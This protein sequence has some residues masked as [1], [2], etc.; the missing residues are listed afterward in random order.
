MALGTQPVGKLLDYEQYIEHQIQRTRARIKMTDVLTACLILATAAL[1]ILFLEVLLDHLVGLP[2]WLRRIVLWS[3]L[4]GGATFAVLRVARPLIS[5]V[6]GLY[7]AKTIEGVDPAFKNSL[8]NYLTLRRRPDAVSR[9]FM[10]AVEAKAVKDLTG[11]EIDAVVDQR[12]LLQMFYALAGVVVIFCLYAA[13][14]PK[15]ILDSAKRA[16]VLDVVRP[17]NTRLVNIKPGDNEELSRVVSGSNV[18]FSVDLQGTRPGRVILHYSVDGGKYYTTTEFAPGANYYDPWQVTLRDV[19]QSLD[20]YLTGG[21]AESLKYHLKVLPAPMVT[22]VS[23]DYEFPAYTGVPPRQDVEGGEIEAIEG[24]RVTVKARTNEPAVSAYFDFSKGPNKNPPMNVSETD[25]HL[26]VGTFE[27]RDSGSYTIKFKTT[28]GQIN[29]DPVVYDIKAI[30]DKAP[31]EVAFLRPDKPEITVPC[32]VQV[33]LVMTASDDFGVKEVLL[34]VREGNETLYSVNLLEKQKPTRRW[35]GGFTIDLA[36]K[37]LKPGAQVEYMMTVRDTKEPIPNRAESTRQVIKVG[38]PV[39]DDERKKINDKAR[40]ETRDAEKPTPPEPGE[41][42]EN[43]N[44]PPPTPIEDKPGADRENPNQTEKPSPAPNAKGNERD[45]GGAENPEQAPGNEPPPMSPEQLARIEKTLNRSRAQQNNNGKTQAPQN[46][47]PSGAPGAGNPQATQPPPDN[48]NPSGPNS[49]SISQGA[50][51]TTPNPGATTD[52]GTTSPPPQGNPGTNPANDSI[53]RAPEPNTAPTSNPPASNN[54]QAQKPGDNNSQPQPSRPSQPGTPGANASNPAATG[55]PNTAKPQSGGQSGSPDA[56]SATKPADTNT[57]PGGTPPP[58]GTSN[59]NTNPQARPAGDSNSPTTSNPGTKPSDSN[60]NSNPT[61]T[62]P[63]PPTTG[64][65][66]PKP[67]DDKSQGQSNK[68]PGSQENQQ[69]GAGKPGGSNSADASNP[70]PG[71][72]NPA[73]NEKT[74]GSNGEAPKP[75]GTKPKAGEPNG[76]NRPGGASDGSKP[77]PGGAPPNPKEGTSANGEKRTNSPDNAARPGDTTPKPGVKPGEEKSNSGSPPAAN[78]SNANANSGTQNPSG[79]QPQ[80]NSTTNENP[81][82]TKPGDPSNKPSGNGSDSAKPGDP[83]NKTQ[84]SNAKPGDPSNKPSGNGSD[85]AKPGD[86]SNKPSGNGS[87]SAKPG[88]P[89]NKPSG[90]GSDS[91]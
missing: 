78:P 50:Q 65:G 73:G 9:S 56:K 42:T 62:N 53:S 38:E 58:P 68:S 69:T 71:S 3:S 86:P 70:K 47:A 48:P 34:S 15:S 82:P 60:A 6:N 36:E 35:R 76:S 43:T 1:G 21:D 63:K 52:P 85:S 39:K 64:N 44:E 79:S 91:A 67:S 13:M 5:H 22:G 90:N 33:P 87:D 77:N 29:P 23:V 18:P 80:N 37:K 46:Q 30:P 45:T 41:Q 88:D 49:N 83:N 32:N 74:K 20:Y 81:S 28:G 75:D 10:A 40:E 24:T 89:S 59:S 84:G 57:K 31:T 51:G 7:A 4:L 54:S 16:F 27:V 26:L 55:A 12:W 19:R 11:V 14:T 8:I 2:L 17:T 25:P 61:N 72:N 66:E